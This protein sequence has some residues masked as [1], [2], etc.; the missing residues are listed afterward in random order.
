MLLGDKVCTVAP[1]MSGA[2]PEAA[3]RAF[4]AAPWA[5]A[6]EMDEWPEQSHGLE[7][8]STVQERLR[9]TTAVVIGVGSNWEPYLSVGD[10]VVVDRAVGM[11]YAGF[12]F[13]GY[14]AT[15]QVRIYGTNTG[16]G[17]RWHYEALEGIMGKLE[18]E[19]IKA[20]GRWVFIKRD[21]PHQT[22]FGLELPDTQKYRSGKAEVISGTGRTP[23]LGIVPGA[24]V[25]YNVHAAQTTL[26]GLTERY[27]GLYPGD[28]ADYC[29]IDS[30]EILLV[31]Q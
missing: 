24:R 19:G 31:T 27:P 3:L 20:V 14:E 21:P 10:A 2:D 12:D 1:T 5:V 22:E 28:P 30:A 7:L 16:Q 15:G 18:Q 17:A 26:E 6:V 13:G 23:G 4:Q 8:P 29:F 25:L 11:W 9:P